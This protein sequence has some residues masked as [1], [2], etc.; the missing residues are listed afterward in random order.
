MNLDWTTFRN[1][2]YESDLVLVGALAFH[3]LTFNTAKQD[4][5]S[6]FWTQKVGLVPIL[7]SRDVGF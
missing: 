4:L 2:P 7:R 5:K 1:P 6:D 3:L